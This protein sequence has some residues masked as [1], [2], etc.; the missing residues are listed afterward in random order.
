LRFRCWRRRRCGSAPR[1]GQ[2]QLA[3][4]DLQTQ[5]IQ[6]L[7]MIFELILQAAALRCQ[8]LDHPV[9]LAQRIAQGLD[10]LLH[11]NILG[12]R[13]RVALRRQCAAGKPQIAFEL[14]LPG[15]RFRLCPGELR[16]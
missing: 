10:L 7:E 3:L 11:R 6:F 12:D 14:V 16:A 4:F 5:G 15:T 13:N 9:L 2:H 8:L 1:L